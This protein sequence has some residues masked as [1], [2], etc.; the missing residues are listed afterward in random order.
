MN[1]YKD[2]YWFFENKVDT[3]TCKKIIALHNKQQK[4]LGRIGTFPKQTFKKLNKK[5]NKSLKEKRNSYVTFFNKDWIFKLLKPFISTANKN[6]GWDFNLDWCE[7]VQITKYVGNKK[8]HYDWHC[9][10]GVEHVENDGNNKIRKLSIVISLSDSKDYRGG[11]F[12][13]QYRS[14]D[15]PTLITPVPILKNQGTVVV[16]P[17]Y[18]WH[19]VKPVTEG[20]RYSLV[21]WVRGKKFK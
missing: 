11:D 13:F 21:A 8:Q 5:Q 19:R 16:F 20:V 6:S 4:E 2:L 18:I 3:R 12:E 7:P 15:D 17:S 9:D 10:T 14:T 1:N